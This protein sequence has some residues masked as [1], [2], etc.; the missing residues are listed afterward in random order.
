MVARSSRPSH[1]D[2]CPSI[3]A[4]PSELW[5]TTQVVAWAKP[6]ENN[7]AQQRCCGLKANLTLYEDN[8][9]EFCSISGNQT[10]VEKCL[11]DADVKDA[12]S[13]NDK[14]KDK[15]NDKDKD[16]KASVASPLSKPAWGLVAMVLTSLVAGTL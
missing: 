12:T 15:D 16:D 7:A 1:S 13:Y 6:S 14:D 2:K 11:D 5:N 10:A 3:R 4:P 8:C 9:F